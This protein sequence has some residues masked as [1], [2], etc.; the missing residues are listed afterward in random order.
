MRRFKLLHID[1]DPNDSLFLQR[2][3]DKACLPVHYH[4]LENAAAAMT[5]LSGHVPLNNGPRDGFPDLL[6]LDLKMPGISG[7]ELLEWLQR[8]PHFP[9]L[10]VV[11]LSSSDRVEDRLLAFQFGARAF[12]TKSIE[13]RDLI[14]S[15]TVLL[16]ARRPA[17][18]A[19]PSSAGGSGPA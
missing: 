14:D 17:L 13:F 11:V 6:V 2:A 10:P 1:D 4:H 16:P 7:F 8:Q 9:N 5:Y 3:L 12:F 15:I 19:A 18:T